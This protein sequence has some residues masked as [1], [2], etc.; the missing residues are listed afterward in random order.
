MAAPEVEFN[1]FP[2]M[3]I[4][5]LSVR[6]RELV[7]LRVAFLKLS[8]YE[9]HQHVRFAREAGL[10]DS[11]IMGV[12]DW[13]SASF[14]PEE[15]ALLALVDG[16]VRQGHPSDEVYDALAQT[17][18]DKAMIGIV[19]TIAFYAALADMLHA[20]EIETESEFVGWDIAR[21]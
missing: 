6:Q 7:I 10:T 17:R 1:A 20:L 8:R 14:A 19:S 21:G 9:W 3:R 11:E 18:T 5:E 4:S 12:Q 16:V 2:S 15:R 13:Q